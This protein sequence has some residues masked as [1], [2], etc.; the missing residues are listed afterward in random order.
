MNLNIKPVITEKSLI[1]AKKGKYTFLLPNSLTKFQ[2]KEIV[3]KLFGVEVKTVKTSN[4]KALTKT[5]LRRQKVKIKA[6]KKAIV[7]L[8]KGQTIEIFG[9]EDKKKKK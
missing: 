2:I 7:T 9:A 4:K 3:G 6:L 8:A 1:E 5:N